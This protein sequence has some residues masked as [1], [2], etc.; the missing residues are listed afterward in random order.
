ML[1]KANKF[2]GSAVGRY[3]A[4]LL[5]LTVAVALARTLGFGVRAG[6]LIP[7][8]ALAFAAWSGYGPG[9]MAAILLVCIVPFVFD[10]RFTLA[11]I[12][13]SGFSLL[14][15][16]SLLISRVSAGRR[17]VEAL[18]RKSNEE[19]E[20]RMQAR[21]QELE[22]ANAARRESEERFSFFMRHL[23][24]AAWMKDPHGRYVYANPT[25]ER[26]FNTPL[27]RLLGKTDAEIFPASVAAQFQE[28][29]QLALSDGRNLETIEALPQPDGIHYS[30][31]SKFPIFSADGKPIMVGGI[32]I[33]ITD[34]R[35]AEHEAHD[36][37]AELE[38]LYKT[39]PVGFAFMD[40]SL[41]YVRVNEQLA[42]INGASVSA[43]IGRTLREILPPPLEDIVEPL[44]RQV[45]EGGEAI[46][47]REL[48]GASPAQPDV[49]RDY[50]V[51]YSPVRTDDGSLIGV[52]V[53]VQDITERKK[54]EEQ[55]RQTAKL[56][57]LGILA[58]GVA[59]DFNNLLTGVLGNASLLEGT[60]QP[61]D[62]A[63]PLLHDVVADTEQAAHLTRQLLAYAGK[64]QFVIEAV[65]VP[66]LVREISSL[67]GVSMT[68]NVELRLE[69]EES[70]S[71]V[72]ADA[73][74]IQQLI[75]NLVINGSE[76]IPAGQPG[77]VRVGVWERRV[78][79]A[80]LRTQPFIAG[81]SPQPGRYVFVEVQDTGIGMDEATVK[82]IF[83]PFF[84]TKFTGRGLGLAAAIGIV[85]GHRGALAV[86][87][88]PGRGSTFLV[89]LPT[90]ERKPKPV[91]PSIAASSAPPGGLVLV[92][93]D[94][95][96]VRRT[97]EVALKRYGYAVITAKTGL[98]G[99][100]VFGQ[101]NSEV[102]VIILD[103]TMPGIDGEETLRELRKIR[104]DVKVVLSSGYDEIETLRRFK[105]EGPDGFLQKPYTS[106]SL[107]A[108]VS[109]MLK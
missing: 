71:C 26:I 44:H 48:R 2:L 46:L 49:E 10:P 15:L 98:E 7:L 20:A 59:H 1:K 58:G 50:L 36:R 109:S 108:K 5:A 6:R 94:E 77:L 21:T 65:N 16:I 91:A 73:S 23:P 82:R 64:G 102:G 63:L 45:L 84:S 53:L 32:A 11:R 43:H 90:T 55:V 70:I 75:M 39:A 57:S 9:A 95:D 27:D 83:D 62:P 106:A 37:L 100:E 14:L 99:L 96:V 52:Q 72:E 13:I 17:Q 29:D 88:F 92:I 25:G 40:T 35:K 93:D 78:D 66:A 54:L 3:V 22:L 107:A 34:R 41:R 86:R 30:V 28:N 97:A 85:R 79:E 31:V 19:L 51:S 42:A 105:V 80:F 68:K 101:N 61:G 12:D 81:V 103:L 33:D 67:I 74:Q 60:I 47:N 69:L 4:A 18:L 38:H 104:R 24:G 89:M 87:S 76:A 56:E 8:T